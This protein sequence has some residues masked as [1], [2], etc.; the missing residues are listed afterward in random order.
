MRGCWGGG[1]GRAE[2]AFGTWQVWNEALD[3]ECTLWDAWVGRA[4]D[5]VSFVLVTVAEAHEAGHAP[6]VEAQV[7]YMNMQA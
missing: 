1:G 6:R 2:H 4:A 7:A 5:S 3:E